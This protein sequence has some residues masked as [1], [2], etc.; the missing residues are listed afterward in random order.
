MIRSLLTVDNYVIVVEHDLS[1]AE[2]ISDVVCCSFGKPG[3][4]GVV[5]MPYTVSE[6]INIFLSGFLP[7]EK[8]K[9][10]DEQISFR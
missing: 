8:Y 2:Y 3:T 10:H 6:G 7:N 1:I 9:F 4:H 5:S